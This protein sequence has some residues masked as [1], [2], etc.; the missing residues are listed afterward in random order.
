MK[1]GVVIVGYKINKSLTVTSDQY[2]WI[3]TERVISKKGKPYKLF[4]YYSNL[5]QLSM[6]LIDRTAKETLS[7]LPLTQV[8]NS[9]TTKRINFLM[10]NIAKDLELFFKRVTGNEKT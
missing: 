10:E 7:R 4:S 3:L 8:N 9:S 2:N 1:Q 6:A 5:K